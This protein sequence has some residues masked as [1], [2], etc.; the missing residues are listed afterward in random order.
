MSSKEKIGIIGDGNVGSALSSGLRRVGRDVRAVGNEAGNVQETAAWADIVVLAVPFSARRQ[1]VETTG[2][3]IHGKTLVDAT[4]AISPTMGYAMEV[5]KS[6]A[7][8]LQRMARESKV[9]KAFNTVFAQN[10]ATGE[11]KGEKLVLPV[12]GDDTGAKAHVIAMGRDI[13]FDAIDA[14]PLANAGLLEAFGVLNIQLGY[15]M[16]MGPG[17]GFTLAR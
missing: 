1:V 17:I 9:V 8:E 7:Q 15:G 13:G 5:S 3:A 16:K 4:N 14:G 10:M 2:N 12:A 6:G 11:I